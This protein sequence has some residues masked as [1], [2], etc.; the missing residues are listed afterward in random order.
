MIKVLSGDLGTFR[1]TLE[2]DCEGLGTT[3]KGYEEAKRL[4]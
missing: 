1:V 4:I 2:K 3:V